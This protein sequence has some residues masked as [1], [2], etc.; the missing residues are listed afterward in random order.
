MFALVDTDLTYIVNGINELL[1]TLKNYRITFHF[2]TPKTSLL[3]TLDHNWVIRHQCREGFVKS[4]HN[5]YPGKSIIQ[6]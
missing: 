3:G 2:T 5:V 4:D 6:H 1:N